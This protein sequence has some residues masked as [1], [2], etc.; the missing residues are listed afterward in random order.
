MLADRR[1]AEEEQ[2][3][4]ALRL[5]L[6]MVPDVSAAEAAE[7]APALE[8][9]PTPTTT[10]AMAGSSSSRPRR[11]RKSRL[12]SDHMPASD[13]PQKPRPQKKK[14]QHSTAL[15]QR[16]PVLSYKL[17]GE[18]PSWHLRELPPP[19]SSTMQDTSFGKHAGKHAGKQPSPPVLV[20][21]R[22]EMRLEDNPALS[23]AAAT[24]RPVVPLFILPTHAEEGGWPLT[25]AVR[26]WQ[27]H[28]LIHLQHALASL[29]SALVVR[30][31]R[32]V[33]ERGT[34]AQL[35]HL[36]DACGASELYFCASH[37]PWRRELDAEVTRVLTAAGVRVHELRGSTLY[38]PWDAKPDERNDSR[39]GFGSVGWFLNACRECPDPPPPL[40]PPS[41]LRAPARWPASLPL[42]ALGLS[43]MPRRA[44]G[45]L[46]DWAAGIRT[47]WAVGEAGAHA[48]LEA[49]LED[50]VA[51]FEGRQRH[52]A[53]ERNT[54]VISPYLRFGELS[55]HTV[56]HR[57][58]QALGRR[59][60][61]TFLRRFAWRDLAYW[62]LWRFPSLPERGFRPHYDTQWWEADPRPYE[63]WCAGRTGYPLVD[64]AMT[65]AR[66]S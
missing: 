44:D 21:L 3:A 27:H 65:Q 20:W 14:P 35:M 6:A 31:A 56:L 49:F 64:A 8:V 23:A 52:R 63:A 16:P 24:G 32:S 62:S 47:W 1:V 5:S 18:H 48:A 46:V 54:A 43:A 55:A 61:P 25:G 4:E 38:A 28:T 58:Q 12:Q 66:A 15:A 42:S 30:D 33:G 50:G 36:A 10:N 26:Y 19:A 29:G 7:A 51:R 9:P 45:S 37:E 13:Q 34:A 40:P 60:P 17:S 59:A 39:M 2:L 41:R 57:V 11:A 53:D 22:Q